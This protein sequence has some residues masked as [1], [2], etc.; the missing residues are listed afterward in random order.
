MTT[1]KI[2]WPANW[3][4]QEGWPEDKAA[5]VDGRTWAET[6]AELTKQGTPLEEICRALGKPEAS[7]DEHDL[8]E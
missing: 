2:E 6:D 8:D 3:N 5:M 4:P 1:K 7:G